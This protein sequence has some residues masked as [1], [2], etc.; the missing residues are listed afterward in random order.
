MNRTS[1]KEVENRILQ[2][3]QMV[4]QGCSYS[5]IVRF[6]SNEWSVSQRQIDKY[7]HKVKERLRNNT[8]QSIEELRSEAT[9][10]YLRWMYK[11]EKEGNI[12]EAAYMQ[13]RIDKINALETVIKKIE[14]TT[15]DDNELLNKL[16]GENVS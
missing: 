12:R 4:L 5:D 10:R 2:C 7:I 1:H 15:N 11:L 14:V 9:S 13:Q 16:L 8:N 6:G 3:Y